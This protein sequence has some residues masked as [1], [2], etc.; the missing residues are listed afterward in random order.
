M[1]PNVRLMIAA[2][3]A[4]ITGI[5][6]G[7]GLFAAFRVNRE[8]FAH[9][10]NGS[11]PLQLV[12][13]LPAPVTDTA[14]PFGIRFQINAPQAGAAAADTGPNLPALKRD[15]AAPVLPSL[16]VTASGESSSAA[17]AAPESAASADAQIAPGVAR[18]RIAKARRLHKPQAD[19]QSTI[20]QSILDAPPR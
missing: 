3:L 16:A 14:A 13:A 5:S 1:F 2:L 15:N 10:P 4:S 12:L 9:L 7:L 19:A 11:A 6:C 18:H 8:P 17:Q 20:P